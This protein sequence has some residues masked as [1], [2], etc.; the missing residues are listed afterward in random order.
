MYFI[1]AG[2]VWGRRKDPH[3]GLGC[4]AVRRGLRGNR[5]GDFTMPRDMP[6]TR[7]DTINDFT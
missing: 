2:V 5:D 4:E 6:T 3:P 7:C 1:A